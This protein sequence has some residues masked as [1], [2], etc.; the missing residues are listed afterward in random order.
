MLRL[1]T[2]LGVRLAVCC[3]LIAVVCVV[4]TGAVMYSSARNNILQ[5]EQDRLFDEFS[6]TAEKATEPMECN[7]ADC[8]SL[9]D[10]DVRIWA[11]SGSRGPIQL[12]PA[13][14]ID[15]GA[16][17]QM[18]MIPQSFQRQVTSSDRVTWLRE[19]QGLNYRFLIGAPVTLT[20]VPVKDAQNPPGSGAA[21]TGPE[22][23]A[24]R[25]VQAI[26]YASYPLDKQQQQIDSLAA[27]TIWLVA[28]MAMVATLTG[29]LLAR[30]IARP[31]RQLRTAVDKLDASAGKLDVNVRGVAELTGLVE[32]FNAANHRLQGTLAELT[33]KEAASQRFVADVSHE[34]RTPVTAMVAMADVLE[35][36]GG[37]PETVQEAAAVTARAARRMHRLTEDLLEIS[38]FDAA[39]NTVHAE[40]FEVAAQLQQLLEA[41]GLEHCVEVDIQGALPFVTDPRRFELIVANLLTNAMAHGGTPIG[42]RAHR[43][44]EHLVVEVTDCGPGVSA[45]SAQHL[46]ERF[47]KTDTSRHRGG[48]GLG[49]SIALENARLLGG[50]LELR[51]HGD[52]TV[53]AV[54][55][56][57]RTPDS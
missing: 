14:G 46:F 15:F 5:A 4:V 39:Q 8:A 6:V 42:V 41:R 2:G 11:E 23:T 13:D 36:G 19:R 17:A 50:T 26:M 48:T 30:W 33:A 43:D 56:P 7:P 16:Y 18:H 24:S 53:F 27:S 20:L 35:H 31:V 3:A 34:I 51:S 49:L 54:R 21:Q 45:E 37:D 40:K 57:P 52:P 9:T 55:L 28:V 25:T 47:Y 10:E 44:G 1:F 29:V 38:R 22:T 12:T 32:A